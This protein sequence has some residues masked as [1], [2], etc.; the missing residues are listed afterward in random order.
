[1]WAVPNAVRPSTLAVLRNTVYVGTRDN[2]L[3]QSFDEGD[4]WNDVTADLPFDVD[5]FRDIVFVGETVYV[6]TDQGVASSVNGVAWDAITD[7]QGETLVVDRFAVDDSSLYGLSGQIVH[8]LSEKSG[9]WQQVT[10]KITHAVST[11]EVDGD[12][13]YVGTQGQGVFRF[14]L[15][16]ME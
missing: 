9:T 3:M 8:Q 14:S 4:T 1:M 13:V 12:T 15:N 2:R 11:F 10:P 6:A 7:T 5:S 16:E